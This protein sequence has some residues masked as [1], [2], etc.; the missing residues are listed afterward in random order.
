MFF[1]G[2]SISETFYGLTRFNLS[3]NKFAR[4]D[5]VISFVV[6]VIFPYLFRKLEKRMNSLK[7]KLQDELST[8][9]KYKILGLYSYRTLKASYEFT[10]IIKYISYL[11]GRSSTHNIPL[12]LSNISLRHANPQ[13]DSFSFS[14]IFSGN[15]NLSTVIGST[16]LRTLEFGGFFLQFLQWYQDSSASQKVIS[17]LPTPDPPNLDKDA[18]RYTNVCPICFQE[19]SIPTVLTVSGYVFCFKC[20][21]SH[22]RKHQL[23]PVTNYPASIDDLTRIYDN[24]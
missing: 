18:K 23:C 3:S 1:A 4:R 21:T 5:F 24:N 16:I 6:L 12:W 11:S 9:D 13:E 2:G 14:D 7:E 20:I 15:V 19:F 10:Q 22:L 8:H 17:Q